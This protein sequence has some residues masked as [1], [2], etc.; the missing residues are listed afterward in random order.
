MNG[1]DLGNLDGDDPVHEDK[2]P[3]SLEESSG[4]AY[5]QV[6]KPISI[7]EPGLLSTFR[8]FIGVQCAITVLGV[9]THWLVVP[10]PP[11]VAV[12]TL[13]GLS[14]LLPGLLFLYLSIP[15]LQ[16]TLQ[17]M[18]LPIGIAW[19]AAGAVA[20]PIL[21]PYIHL[22]YL[23][24]TENNP[25]DILAQVI[26]WRQLLLLLIPLVVVSWQYAIH[27]VV[28]FCMGTTALNVTLLSRP[29]LFPELSLSSL[30]GILFVQLMIFFLV[31]HMIVKLMSVQR[32]QRQ[33]LTEANQR[34]A[35]Y[36]ST[37]EQLT[38][39]RERNRL[40]RELHDVLAHTLSGVA[41][42]LEGLRAM[43]RLDPERASGLL[44]HALQAIRAGLTETRRALKELRAK[45]LEDL[46]M[47]LAVRTLAESFASRF[48]FRLAL[49][50]DP[51]LGEYP[52][53]VEQCIYRIAQEALANIANHA[54][55][56][57][58]QIVLK[59][60]QAQLQLTIHDDGCGFDPHLPRT[61]NRYGL[62]GMRERAEM[63]GGSL[64]V[65]SQV[66]KGTQISFTYGGNP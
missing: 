54:Q 5:A 50:I 42:E 1:Y 9:I 39:S 26:L 58:A 21:D 30:L 11:R 29:T 27:H 53:E 40:A 2:L 56:Q 61:E 15:P 36:A 24:T 55:A 12:V 57:R 18:Y 19:A 10:F 65:E 23:H 34:L 49:D 31:G 41:V 20:S 44:S 59:G 60:S 45:P 22:I 6:M 43:L 35:Q 52:T 8:L 14:L 3:Q 66:G 17:S 25:P 46:G 62:L 38:I 48:D 28:L 64:L 37:L 47:A 32:Q 33:Q 7:I 16:R 51:E 63:I 4:L 13:A